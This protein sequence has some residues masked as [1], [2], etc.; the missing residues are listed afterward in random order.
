MEKNYNLSNDYLC[1]SETSWRL[2]FANNLNKYLNYDFKKRLQQ[3]LYKYGLRDFANLGR[4]SCAKSFSKVSLKI[5][6]INFRFRPLL[7]QCLAQLL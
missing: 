6:E 5:G 4:S 3:K 2:R 1:W 7:D